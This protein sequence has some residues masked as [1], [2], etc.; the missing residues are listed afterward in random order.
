[1][2]LMGTAGIGHIPLDKVIDEF[3]GGNAAT[4][5]TFQQVHQRHQCLGHKLLSITGV[6]ARVTGWVQA[7][8]LLAQWSCCQSGLSYTIA[9]VY[10]IP[11][12]KVEHFDDQS[13]NTPH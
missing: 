6:G 10:N 9:F 7:R 13:S 1:M 12:G 11:V 5:I 4:C 2:G 8:K 3:Y